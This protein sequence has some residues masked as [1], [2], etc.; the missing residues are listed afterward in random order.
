M[1]KDRPSVPEGTR[2]RRRRASVRLR[3]TMAYST[4][5][6]VVFASVLGAS[7]FLVKDRTGGS[8]TAVSI[9]CSKN[10]PAQIALSRVSGSQQ[11]LPS[12]PPGVGAGK[13]SGSFSQACA[14]QVVMSSSSSVVYRTGVTA[15]VS[16][17]VKTTV[18]VPPG[19][20]APVRDSIAS[21]TKA[22]NASRDQTLNTFLIETV[23]A[24]GLMAV[25]SIGLGWWMAG[26]ALKPVH[27]I[28][29][30][31]RRLS[32]QTLHDRINLDG[33]QDELKELADTFDAMLSR[34][35]QAFT[36]QRRFV[37]NAS[38]ELRTP[39]ATERVLIDEALANPDATPEE[40]RAILEQI[41]VNSE[42]NE[43]LINALLALARSGRGVERWSAVDLAVVVG[44][45]CSSCAA[46]AARE[47]VGFQTDLQPALCGGD[48]GLLERLAGNLVENSI[49]HNT[50]GGWVALRTGVG[51]GHSYLEVSNS[52]LV[53]EAS[54]VSGLVEPFRRAGPDRVSSGEGFGLGLSIVDAIVRAHG[55][56][57]SIGA[58]SEGGLEVRVELRERVPAL[59]D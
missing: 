31:A 40:L 48:P 12:P 19:L 50:P 21:L 20:P 9:I 35:D 33:P 14:T 47:E 43:R 23:I 8:K 44:R 58:R 4:L 3:L 25:L 7:Y 6:V 30:T 41:R 57:L 32:E 59:S 38:H 55:G 11:A 54:A 52:G 27:R 16:T 1:S 56:R 51:D 13:I 28:T 42:E 36:T 37:A 34:L 5:F 45:A 22:V 18:G 39:L 15:P 26:R 46:E 29:D 2:K 49:R 24:L 17:H 10:G 53:V